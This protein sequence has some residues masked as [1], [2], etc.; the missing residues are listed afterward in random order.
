M[1]LSINSLNL[2][3][4]PKEG[5]LSC[6]NNN[7]IIIVDTAKNEVITIIDEST[8]YEKT[9]PQG[10]ESETAG[11]PP[12]DKKVEITKLACPEDAQPSCS[13]NSIIIMDTT[14]N[15]V[16]SVLP[17]NLVPENPVTQGNNSEAARSDTENKKD[18]ATNS[19]SS[20]CTDMDDNDDDVQFIPQKVEIINICDDSAMPSPSPK[21]EETSSSDEE[22]AAEESD[23]TD[24]LEEGELSKTKVETPKRSSHS[25]SVICLDD[26]ESVVEISDDDDDNC[27]EKK[28]L[29]NFLSLD[30]HK[31]CFFKYFCIIF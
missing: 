12:E 1:N 14:K 23:E 31:V 17:T 21:D 7:S 11:H 4:I 24:E 5:R 18:E 30:V 20:A 2:S 6:S 13:D 29:P 28:K 3:E 16:I 22:E 26:S 8:V 15:E 27:W 10:N 19:T 9:V 25:K